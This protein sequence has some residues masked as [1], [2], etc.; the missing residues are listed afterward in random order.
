MTP[1]AIIGIGVFLAI[2]YICAKIAGKIMEPHNQKTD[3]YLLGAL[4]G[5]LGVVIALIISIAKR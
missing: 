5:P 3:G 4:L 2:V 1:D